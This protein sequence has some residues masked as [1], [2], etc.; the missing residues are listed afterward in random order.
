MRPHKA[1]IGAIFASVLLVL[2]AV[3]GGAGASVAAADTALST[4]AVPAIKGSPATGG[5]VAGK[6][7]PGRS[8][9]RGVNALGA[10]CGPFSYAAGSQTLGAGQTT[11]GVAANFTVAKPYL[12]T[13]TACHSLAEAAVQ[14][15]ATYK[16]IVEVGWNVDQIVNG[17]LEPHLFVYHWV[18]G[19]TSCYNGCGWIDYAANP[20]NAGASLATVRAAA[21]PS[22]VKKFHI[23]HDTSTTCGASSGGWWAGYDNTWLGCFPD[24]LWTAPTFTAG[25]LVQ[26]FGEVS[27]V[28]TSDCTDMGLQGRNGSAATLPLDATDPAIISSTTLLGA[29]P[30]GTTAN[31]NTF[32]AGGT[33]YT[34][35]GFPSGSPPATRTLAYGGPGLGSVANGC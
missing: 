6:G 34:V 30:A 21:W 8:P 22:N 13:A 10:A 18:N 29:L 27:S 16:D 5:K 12:N 23:Q 14:G 31:L 25:T 1:R 4:P 19:A 9:A 15:G 2:T 35:Q 26:V 3:L 32:T 7:F 24:S 11:A 17:D 33:G 20:I 28:G